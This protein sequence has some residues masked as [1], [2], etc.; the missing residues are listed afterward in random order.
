MAV[1]KCDLHS[2]DPADEDLV[3]GFTVGCVGIDLLDELEGVRVVDTGSTD[4]C[5]LRHGTS[6]AQDRLKPFI[7]L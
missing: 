7:G 5:D 1:E 3:G 2:S 4:Y 6:Y